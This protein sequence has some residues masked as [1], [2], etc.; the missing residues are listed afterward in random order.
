MSSRSL[1]LMV[2]YTISLYDVVLFED[3][4]RVWEAYSVFD[5][6]AVGRFDDI[7]LVRRLLFVV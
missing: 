3:T 4:H 5:D 6:I 7:M 2:L 1:G